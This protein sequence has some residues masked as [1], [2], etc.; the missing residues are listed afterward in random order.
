MTYQGMGTVSPPIVG[1][2]AT[3][4]AVTS[5]AATSSNLSA[6]PQAFQR[7]TQ[8]QQQQFTDAEQSVAAM[9]HACAENSGVWDPITL[10]CSIDTVTPQGVPWWL[11]PIGAAAVLGV[12]G[13][14]G[15]KK[16]WF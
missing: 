16:R 2:G 3:Y 6:G 10:T 11:W 4:A 8:Q 12:V 7:Y 9:E 1:V 14:I 15:T 13:Y 5:P